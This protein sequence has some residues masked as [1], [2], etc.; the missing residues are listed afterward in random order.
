MGLLRQKSAIYRKS[1]QLFL[2][3]LSL[4]V[5]KPVFR[6]SD[7]VGHKP[8]CTVTEHGSGLEIS[9]LRSRGIVLSV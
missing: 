8:G 9:D 3:Y 7:D 1:N 2:T 4:V 5:R 6:V